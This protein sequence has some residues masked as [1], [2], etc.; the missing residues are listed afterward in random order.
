M[1]HNFFTYHINKNKKDYH[2]QDG[3]IREKLSISKD[4]N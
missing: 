2:S 1:R 4:K 3:K